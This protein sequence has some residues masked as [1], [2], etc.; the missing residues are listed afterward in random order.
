MAT[1]VNIGSS[2]PI[3]WA[4]MPDESGNYEWGVY[5][6]LKW[7]GTGA[8]LKCSCPI[9]WAIMPDESGNYEILSRWRFFACGS[10]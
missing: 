1:Y 9:Y 10:E 6:R 8:S 2:C 5:P 3:Y 4:I 7:L